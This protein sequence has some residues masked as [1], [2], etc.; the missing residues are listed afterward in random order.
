[1][2]YIYPPVAASPVRLK[3]QRYECDVKKSVRCLDTLNGEL[4]WVNVHLSPRGPTSPQASVTESREKVL[5]SLRVSLGNRDTSSVL[6]RT[7]CGRRNR[8]S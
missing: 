8:E 3:L 2:S 6:W 7:L 5:I 1:M 4:R